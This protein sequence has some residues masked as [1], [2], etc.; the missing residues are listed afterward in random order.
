MNKNI[1]LLFA[2]LLSRL[3]PAQDNTDIRYTT[4]Q[5]TLIKQRFIDRYENVFM[6][7]VP[8]RH[9]LKV[10]IEFY[11]YG[12][13]EYGT[14]SPQTKSLT[15][16]YEYK[17]L[18]SLSMGINVKGA[19]GWG[20]SIGWTGSMSANAQVRWYFDMKRRISEGK[21]ANNFSENYLAIVGEKNWQTE[22]FALPQMKTGIEFGLQRRF[23]NNGLIDFAAGVY[24]QKSQSRYNPYE[25]LSLERKTNDFEISTRTTLGLAFGDWEKS[26]RLPA[27]DLLHCD[28]AVNSQWKILW[29]V[30]KISSNVI[31]GSL[32]IAYERK[33]GDSPLSI[34]TQVLA[35]YNKFSAGLVD[36]SSIFNTLHYQIHSSV[37]GRYYF[38]QQRNIR[39]GVGGNNLSGFYAGPHMD[40]VYYY[41]TVNRFSEKKHLGAGITY[42]YQK[43]LFRNAYIDI[44]GTQSWNIL[45]N[46]MGKNRLGS[47]RIG[48]GLSF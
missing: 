15:L 48:F 37:Q 13:R 47:L 5:D 34:N 10:G 42:G 1:L 28:E 14:S 46:Q 35:D 41:N 45:R 39:K 3:A 32:G 31:N 44:T 2:L 29:P 8:T 26:G 11:P 9:I 7:K 4:E 19:G 18:P 21:S 33:L 43:T 30:V 36:N 23:F 40:Y 24:Y 20:S 12:F 16:G 38:L 17:L 27:C 6:T 22:F 25:F